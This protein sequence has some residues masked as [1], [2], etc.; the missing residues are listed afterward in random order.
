MPARAATAAAT[1]SN[2]DEGT[3]DTSHWVRVKMS[4]A[5]QYFVQPEDVV[6]VH[7]RDPGMQVIKKQ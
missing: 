5:K 1:A 7:K 6:E 2:Q 4:D 3:E